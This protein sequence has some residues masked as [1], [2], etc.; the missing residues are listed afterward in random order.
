MRPS[1]L[2]AH[3]VRAPVWMPGSLTLA[4]TITA[5]TRWYFVEGENS[6]SRRMVSSSHT[7]RS[8]HCP[9]KRNNRA[10][11]GAKA[12]CVRRGSTRCGDGLVR[13]GLRASVVREVWQS[14][15]VVGHHAATYAAAARRSS[16]MTL[17]QL[18][19]EAGPRSFSRDTDVECD[20]PRRRSGMRK[21]SCASRTRFQR[22]HM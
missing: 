15:S 10:A 8:W 21:V 12:E 3:A 13:C 18:L 5:D 17:E 19:V 16:R 14:T 6:H 7:A 9:T 4:R 11:S 2:S 1:Y 20:S 22:Q